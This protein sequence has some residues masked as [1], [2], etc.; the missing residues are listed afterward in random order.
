MDQTE[1]E[2]GKDAEI[3]LVEPLEGQLE[4]QLLTRSLVR[5]LFTASSLSA[6]ATRAT[7]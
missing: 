5:H 3:Y 2:E 1:W 4:C 7:C 6:G